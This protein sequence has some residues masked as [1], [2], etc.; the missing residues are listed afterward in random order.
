MNKLFRNILTISLISIVSL[1]LVSC[2]FNKKSNNQ[3]NQ[4]NKTESNKSI[5]E[6]KNLD[7]S[8]SSDTNSTTIEGTKDETFNTIEDALKNSAV[9]ERIAKTLP[10]NIKL[11][12]KGNDLIYT[13]EVKGLSKNEDSKKVLKEGLKTNE[14]IFKNLADTMLS[15]IKGKEMNITIKYFNDKNELVY[16]Q[17]NN[18]KK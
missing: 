2:N 4:V 16:E 6:Q 11:S 8:N 18:Y 13:V 10:K 12:A 15:Q 1:G 3:D 5:D 17:T 9:R 14:S 7:T